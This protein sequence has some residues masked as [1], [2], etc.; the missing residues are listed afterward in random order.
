MAQ[1]CLKHEYAYYLRRG[2]IVF[3]V[4][5]GFILSNGRILSINYYLVAHLF[6]YCHN[7][8]ISNHNNPHTF[9][10]QQQ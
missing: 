8:P 7:K 4:M 5:L 9:S 6:Y 3:Y 2:Y 10:S 1:L